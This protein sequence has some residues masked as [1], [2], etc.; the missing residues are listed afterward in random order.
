M[1]SVILVVI[2]F[3][4]AVQVLPV[5]VGVNRKE[6]KGLWV[7][8]GL[9]MAVL[10][11][12]LFWGGL[13]LGGLFMHYMDGFSGMVL[14][15]GFSLIG[16]RMLMEVFQI[17]KGERTYLIDKTKHIVFAGLAQAINTFLAG[18]LFTFFTFD[19]LPVYEILFITTLVLALAGMWLSASKFN[20][21]LAALLYLVGGLVMLIAGVY[22]AFFAT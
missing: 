4:L 7:V 2:L 16:I 17:R 9:I 1:Q 3:F 21:S 5:A 8:F 13:Q 11:I 19:Y 14:F 6:S 10:Q 20:L 12:A 22:L 15:L 18:L